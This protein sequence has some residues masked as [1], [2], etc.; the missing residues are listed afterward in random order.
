[1]KTRSGW[2]MLMPGDRL[3]GRSEE[4]ALE[5]SDE[6]LM[7]RCRAG[8]VRAMDGLVAR[9]Y[10]R[11]YRFAYRMLNDPGAAED[12]AQDALLRAY[13]GAGRFRPDGRFSTWILTIAA[14]LCRSELR[15]RSR[16]TE[17]AWEE[18]AEIAAPGSVEG[19]VLRRL[20]D[21]EVVRAL[22]RLSPDH[23][24]V[25]VLF[26][27]EGLSH[28]EIAEV[29]GCALGTVKSRLHYALARLRRLMECRACPP[30]S[31]ERALP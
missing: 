1:M 11:L 25:L 19:A 5:P 29:C 20:Q 12:A 8:D 2:R 24:M 15:R 22:N 30:R 21:E 18:A 14:N 4:G 27:F 16:R 7:A 9:Y 23:R 10:H 26:Y 28:Q 6:E 13:A 17:C 3:D 31:E